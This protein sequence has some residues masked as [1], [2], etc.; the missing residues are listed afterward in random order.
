MKTVFIVGS[1]GALGRE[2]IEV[3]NSLGSNYRIAGIAGFR[4]YP[5]L[6]EQTSNNKVKFVGASKDVLEKLAVESNSTHVFDVEKE[7]SLVLEDASPDI[8]LFLSSG[9][10][11]LPSIIRLLSRKLNVAIANKESIIAGGDLVFNDVTR[12]YILPVDSE[13]SAIYQG[14]VGESV[15]SIERLIITA[16]GGPFLD[17]DE[18][19]MS[20]VTVSEA[21]KHPNWKMG[22]K[23]TIDSATMV[24]KAFEIM[25][26]HFLFGIPYSKIKSLV[27]RESIVH[28]I[29]E[30]VDGFQKAILSIPTMHLS[31][32]Y[33]ITY[34]ERLKN[35]YQRLNLEETGK[36]SFEPL[37]TY[38]F[39]AFSTVLKYGSQGGNF[40]P[41]IIA[42]DEVLVSQFLEGNIPYCQVNDYISEIMDSFEHKDI[43]SYEEI[44]YFYDEAL[45]MTNKILRRHNI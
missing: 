33:S 40:L 32:Q 21:L 16:S 14:L 1:T 19:L 26:S 34:P 31:L 38:K 6:L 41:I 43:H 27:H 22:K 29:V 18:D 7:L 20:S 44:E 30:F 23:I 28:S 17:Y 5:L 37:D 24:N 39:K 2:A 11:A 4:N 13:A 45:S 9:I 36:L 10:T 35:N 12:P 3:V 42:I 8:T 25:E 15:Q